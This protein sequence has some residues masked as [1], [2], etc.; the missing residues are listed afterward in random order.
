MM[1]GEL[2]DEVIRA[3]PVLIGVVERNRRLLDEMGWTDAPLLDQ[4][5]LATTLELAGSSDD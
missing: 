4:Y 3:D 2:T 1:L 5:N